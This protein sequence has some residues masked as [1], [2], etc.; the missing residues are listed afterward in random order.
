MLCPQDKCRHYHRAIKYPRKCFYEPQCWRGW[1]DILVKIL[2]R[3]WVF[4]GEDFSSSGKQRKRITK[5]KKDAK[6]LDKI[7]S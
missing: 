7:T 4:L 5:L 2:V 3:R 6:R 1:V